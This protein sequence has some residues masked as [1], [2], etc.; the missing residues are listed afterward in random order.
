MRLKLYYTTDEIT[1][2]LYTSGMQY[3]LQDNTEYRGLY[4]TYLTGEVYTGA[5][6]DSKTSKKLIA[7]KNITAKN[8]EYETLKREL[9]LTYKQPVSALN[10]PT[11][12][13][14]KAGSYTRYF[15]KK[16]NESKI[17]EID[18]PQFNMWQ[19]KQFDPALYSAIK[20][21]WYISGPIED[22]RPSIVL[23]RGVQTKNTT[24][25]EIA[26]KSM[27]GISKVLTD[28]LQYYSDITYLV[29]KD[30]NK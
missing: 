24:Q 28:P 15:I 16:V 30:I 23:I 5:T 1:N 29:P 9:K 18:E 2:N 17:I 13:Q 22:S 19:S 14:L 20:M 21:Q 27:P 26:E 10:A 6:W 8:V 11:A 3:M 4:H 25:I 12:E 7:Y